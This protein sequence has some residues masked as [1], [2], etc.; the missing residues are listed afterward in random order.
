MG[1][2]R[3]EFPVASHVSVNQ[4]RRSNEVG[5]YLRFHQGAIF[6]EN[7]TI[8]AGAGGCE[9]LVNLGR[10]VL[11]DTHPIWCHLQIVMGHNERENGQF[12]RLGFDMFLKF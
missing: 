2:E 4:I 12:S 11:V 6:L 9:E 10:R 8:G 5:T 7:H 1:C 3:R